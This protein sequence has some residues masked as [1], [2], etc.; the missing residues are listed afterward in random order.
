[1]PQ[2]QNAAAVRAAHPGVYD[3]LSDQQ[4][5]AGLAKRGLAPAPTNEDGAL[6]ER[7]HPGQG[8]DYTS[9]FEGEL[10]RTAKEAAIGLARSP[11]DMVKGMM[12]PLDAL[13]GIG[14]TVTHPREAVQNLMANPREGG[15]LLGQMLLAPRVPGMVDAAVANGPGMV[16]RGMSAVGRGAEALGTSSAAAKLRAL[17]PMEALTGHIGPA[18]ASTVGPAVLEHGGKFLQR[19][20]AALEGLMDAGGEPAAVAEGA[21]PPSRR[22]GPARFSKEVPNFGEQLDAVQ[23]PPEM[24]SAPSRSISGSPAMEGL[25]SA[26]QTANDPASAWVND[27]SASPISD[28]EMTIENAQR[29]HRQVEPNA[30]TG[31]GAANDLAG[32]STKRPIDTFLDNDPQA[33]IGG[34]GRMTGQFEEGDGGLR[35]IADGKVD[36]YP[37]V[38]K[39]MR[40]SD[41]VVPDSRYE[42]LQNLLGGTEPLSAEDAQRAFNDHFG[43]DTPTEEETLMPATRARRTGGR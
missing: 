27:A 26:V 32:L 14:H 10:G 13:M 1:M 22:L 5:E 43:L 34:E 36:R 31:N 30:F 2:Y 23:T 38:E 28:M 25:K 29:G 41:K 12:H 15:S 9:A 21:V 11:L 16:G 37:D 42:E 24:G 35:D 40:P 7:Y 39:R 33:R 20:G 18:I 17:A 6:G 3:D 19:G 4:I 8:D